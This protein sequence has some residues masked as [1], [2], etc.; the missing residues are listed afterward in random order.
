M[1]RA[2]ALPEEGPSLPP[3]PSALVFSTTSCLSL[4]GRSS[5]SFSSS[6]LPP[7]SSASLWRGV[8]G[9]GVQGDVVGVLALLS[10]VSIAIC[11]GVV[12]TLESFVGLSVAVGGGV[13]EA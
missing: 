9:G 3:L 2:V 7:R 4:L 8:A 10:S 13:R 11:S 5:G 1:S 12:W 6:L